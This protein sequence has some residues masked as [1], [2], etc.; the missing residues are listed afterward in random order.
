MTQPKRIQFYT[1]AGHRY[2]WRAVG[3][4]GE[5]GCGGQ[6]HTRPRDAY[7]AAIDWLG[8]ADRSDLVVPDERDRLALARLLHAQHPE[9]DERAWASQLDP[10][11]KDRAT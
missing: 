8:V 9:V 7:L 6:A 10:D 4:N 2:R 3:A 5:K 11:S 1:G